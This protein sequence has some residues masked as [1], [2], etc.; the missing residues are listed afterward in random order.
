MSSY[1]KLE[2]F[3][4][5]RIIFK[6]LDSLEKL[7]QI[8]CICLDKNTLKQNDK[9]EVKKVWQWNKNQDKKIEE[10]PEK[11]DDKAVIDAKLFECIYLLSTA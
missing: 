11:K 6:K 9:M 3:R 10:V 5:G 4:E 8:D 1:C 2:V 7:G